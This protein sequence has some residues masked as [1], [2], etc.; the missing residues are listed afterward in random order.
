MDR[1]HVNGKWL[2]QPLT[3]TQR[4][5]TEM[6][7]CLVGAEAVDLVLHTPKGV[8]APAWASAP[9]VEIR[10]A[11]VGGV[12]FEQLYLPA[13]TAG[14]MLLNF[15][16]PAP[17]LKR[18]QLVTMHDATAFRHPHTFR[19]AF[20]AFYWVMYVVLS[21]T[22]RLL[23]TVSD[24]SADELA[25]VL[26]VDRGRFLVAP[27]AADGLT[28]LDPARPDLDVDGGQ[29]LVVGTLAQHKNLTGAVAALTAS[30]R[31]VVVVGAAGRDQVFA[32]IADLRTAATVAG[33]LTDAELVW[34]YRNSRAL[35]FPS[36]YEGFGLPVL[37]AQVLGC[38]VISSSAASLP[39]VGGRGALYFDPDDSRDLLARIEEFER[40]AGLAADLIERGRLNAERYSWER[41]AA[42]VLT[43]ALGVP[44]AQLSTATGS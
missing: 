11:P 39:E 38:P 27:C 10:P 21:R 17:V 43:G 35:V 26:R 6:V 18:R 40:D 30:G 33:R 19:R 13:A 28:Q 29:Y 2:A 37:E 14:R 15:A 3:G 12:L 16:G 8:E 41:S 24:F 1:V 34:L 7:R 42:T 23:L 32:A 4:Y 36:K 25:C 22:A 9:H 31:R 5:A 44:L 20:V